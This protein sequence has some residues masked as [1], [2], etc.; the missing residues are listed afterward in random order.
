MTSKTLVSAAQLLGIW[1]APEPSSSC[2]GGVVQVQ[3]GRV[4]KS[5]VTVHTLMPTIPRASAPLRR[6]CSMLLAYL[7]AHSMSN[8]SACT[9]CSPVEN[10]S[11]RS[12]DR[13]KQVQLPRQSHKENKTVQKYMGS[14]ASL[15]C[16]HCVGTCQHITSCRPSYKHQGYSM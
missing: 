10:L 12:K 4:S 5:F 13:Q 15:V 14:P 9:K 1:L 8:K 2:E 3:R 6:D 16:E 11:L 7:G